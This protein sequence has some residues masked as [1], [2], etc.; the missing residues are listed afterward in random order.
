MI[1]QAD[2]EKNIW[3]EK[4]AARELKGENF[5]LDGLS[6]HDLTALRF[7]FHSG[8]AVQISRATQVRLNSLCA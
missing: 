6:S 1:F 3:E 7:I 8:R 2:S 5:S 4:T